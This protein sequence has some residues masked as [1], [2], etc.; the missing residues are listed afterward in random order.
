MLKATIKYGILPVG[1]YFSLPIFET[2]LSW[3]TLSLEEWLN[4]INKPVN[5]GYWLELTFEASTTNINGDGSSEIM[6]FGPYSIDFDGPITLNEHQI[7]KIN[8]TYFD[9]LDHSNTNS[10]TITLDESNN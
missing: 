1:R 2:Q 6:F 8:S 7:R 3:R 4:A 10:I 9:M 5:Y